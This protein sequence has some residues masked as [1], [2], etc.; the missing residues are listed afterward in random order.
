[1]SQVNA[2]APGG[3]VLAVHRFVVQAMGRQRRLLARASFAGGGA[4]DPGQ[5]GIVLAVQAVDGRVLY[6]AAIPGSAFR[7]NRSRS[8]FRYV[9]RPGQAIA[10]ANGL[11]QVTIR[12]NRDGA[13]VLAAGTSLDLNAVAAEPA[14]S[15]ALWMGGT[16]VRDLTL[17]CSVE[18]AAITSC[19]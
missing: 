16:C 11:R 6:E 15:W 13:D 5:T 3:H 7:S 18:P 14:L 1:V 2:A 12:L 19:Q 4:L 9:G 10:T 17:A 8:V